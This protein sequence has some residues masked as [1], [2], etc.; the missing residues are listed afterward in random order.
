MG[1]MVELK[2]RE[3]SGVR[4]PLISNIERRVEK[5]KA[6]RCREDFQPDSVMTTTRFSRSYAF[7]QEFHELV[8]LTWTI[9]R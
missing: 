6:L 8:W 4:A 3:G 1:G 7:T 5:M 2:S 9:T